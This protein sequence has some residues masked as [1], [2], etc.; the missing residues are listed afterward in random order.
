MTFQCKKELFNGY[1]QYINKA[2]LSLVN[3]LGTKQRSIQQNK[4]LNH[5]RDGSRT[6]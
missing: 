2:N 5:P 1:C 3:K 6:S 4:T